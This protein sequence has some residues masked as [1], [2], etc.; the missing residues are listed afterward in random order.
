MAEKKIIAVVGATGAAGERV[1]A[2]PVGRQDP[3]G[4]RAARR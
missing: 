3:R 1:G 4:Q 2:R